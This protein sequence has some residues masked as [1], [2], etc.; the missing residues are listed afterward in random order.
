VLTSWNGPLVLDADA[1]NLIAKDR[2]LIGDL[3]L[4]AVITPHPGEMSRLM[5]L[6]DDRVLSPAGVAAMP[7]ET[8]K[9][10]SEALGCITVL[11]GART[12][13]TDSEQIWLNLYG[14]DGM[15][16]GGSGDV[17][18]GII[19]SLMAQGTDAAD[20]SKAGVLLHALAGDEAAKALGRMS[21]KAA[22]LI[23]YLPRVT[24]MRG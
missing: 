14:N 20:A 8:A 16:S 6:F 5:A 11:K 7:V 12:V 23:A 10:C 4:S 1:L 18:T 17:L 19:G 15:A 2:S 13:V 3:P 24:Y 9:W 21:M 22:D